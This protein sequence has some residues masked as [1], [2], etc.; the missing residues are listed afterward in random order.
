MD[1]YIPIIKEFLNENLNQYSPEETDLGIQYIQELSEDLTNDYGNEYVI[2]VHIN[3]GTNDGTYY[4]DHE[5]LINIH[6]LNNLLQS[7]DW[8]NGDY[9][10]TIENY[11]GLNTTVLLPIT[12]LK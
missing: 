12:I 11:I 5:P 6:G 2:M 9:A 10:I 1:S 7:Q 8:A 3:I 4:M